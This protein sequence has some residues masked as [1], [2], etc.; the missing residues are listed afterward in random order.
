MKLKSI[1]KPY[2]KHY[3]T[4]VN[5]IEQNYFQETVNFVNIK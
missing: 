3:D 4:Y 2:Q 5:K 1:E